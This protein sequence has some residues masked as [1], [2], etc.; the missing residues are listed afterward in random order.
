MEDTTLNNTKQQQRDFS[1][2][3]L[4]SMDTFGSYKE[5]PILQNQVRQTL[6]LVEDDDVSSEEEDLTT[7]EKSKS[8][9]LDQ[10]KINSIRKNRPL[11]KV[12]ERAKNNSSTTA[13]RDSLKGQTRLSA[14]QLF[15]LLNSKEKE[16]ED[17]DTS[18]EDEEY[19]GVFAFKT[20]MPSPK[21]SAKEQLTQYYQE[22]NYKLMTPVEEV[23]E[24]DQLFNDISTSSNSDDEDEEAESIMHRL[25]GLSLDQAPSLTSGRT[26]PSF[27]EISPRPSIENGSSQRPSLE[28]L[29]LC[30]NAP[31]LPSQQSNE[32]DSLLSDVQKLERLNKALMTPVL[33]SSPPANQL[34]PPHILEPPTPSSSSSS[35]ASVSLTHD[36][37]TYRRMASKTHDRHIQFTYATYLIQLVNS[38]DNKL[39]E[40]TR[41]RLQEEAEYWIERLAK[42]NYAGALYIKGQWHRDFKSSKFVG[43]QY[44]KV[45]HTKAF[46]CFQQAAKYGSTEAHYEL[47]EYWMV[48]KEY[49]KSMSSYRFAASKNH[50]QSLYKLAN[51]LLRGLLNQKKDIQQG[52][53]FLRRAADA[54][55]PESAQSAFDLACIFSNDLESVDLERTPEIE[56]FMTAQNCAS[57]VHYFKEADYYG[58]VNATYRLGHIHEQGHNYVKPDTWEAFKYFSKAAERKHEGAMLELSRMYRDGI[59]DCLSPR[60]EMAYTWCLS[61]AK[62]G[63]EIAE[64]TLGLYYERGV[65]VYPD[66]AQANEWFRKAASKGYMP[67]KEKLSPSLRNPIMQGQNLLDNFGIVA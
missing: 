10:T 51:I 42:S 11:P 66:Q 52:V 56:A 48:R 59:M 4:D 3:P 33:S 19:G 5:E 39:D 47:A 60:P 25:S 61:A 2:K 54:N 7:L 21:L 67:A 38:N 62:N 28:K 34:S 13:L 37:K 45:N 44:K 57:A 40:D 50:V 63:N 41:K 58:I 31:L 32:E 49:K 64:F 17:A 8:S 35:L 22:H 55:K 30:S 29:A 18:D 16:D 12:P 53:I 65:G 6:M 9:S 27:G 1:F 23:D 15:Q 24:E 26:T 36:V 14:Q 43:S 20:Q 46:K